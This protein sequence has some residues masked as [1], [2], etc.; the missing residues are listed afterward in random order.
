MLAAAAVPA[1][2]TVYQLGYSNSTAS[3]TS[4]TVTLA[5]G[6]A[7]SAAVSSAAADAAT[8]TTDAGLA[9]YQSANAATG[10]LTLDQSASATANSATPSVTLSATQ[11][12]E[13]I[14]VVAAAPLGTTVTGVGDGQGNTYTQ[15]QSAASSGVTLS[16]WYATTGA[17]SGSDT[18]TVTFSGRAKVAIMAFTIMG[19]DI[20]SPFDPAL[21]TVPSNSGTGTTASTT[22]TTSNPNDFV[23]G[24]AA[25]DTGKT[26]AAGPGLTL[27]RQ[28][29]GSETAA[30]EYEVV[31]TAQTGATVS[32]TW[33]GS[34]DWAFIADAVVEAFPAA[35]AD[36]SLTTPVAS[37]SQAL[38]TTTSA[39]LWS[40]AYASGEALYSGAWTADFWASAA[41]SGALSVSVYAVTSAN[42]VSATLLTTGTTGTVG[43]AKG[44]VKTTFTLPAGTVPSNGMILVVITAPAG[45]PASFTLYW[46]AGQ[47]TNFQ[48]PA[49]YDYV[50]KINSP[51]GTAWNVNLAV[52]SS[53]GLARLTNATVWLKVPD[54][55]IYSVFSQQI[56][57]LSGSFTK[58]TGSAVTLAASTTMYVYLYSTASSVGASSIVLTLKVQPSAASPY[59]TY[60][61]VLTIN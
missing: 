42:G 45:G 1:F 24:A 3:I 56:A 39:Y 32:C 7:G 40:A 61:I 13:V 53:A 23:I 26:T 14:Y 33:S 21:T 48:T 57:L 25:V 27:I 55:P 17:N 36:T 28:A 52:A 8:S 46:G 44:E 51:A 11:A 43:T 2:A 38:T 49:K 22:V 6:T 30:G 15:R 54:S 12:S 29:L 58:S 16:T 60:T 50:L 47:S 37:G 31:T 9:Y 18:V 34:T 20:A 4:P 19:A 59:S 5:A 41:T 35:T 10:A